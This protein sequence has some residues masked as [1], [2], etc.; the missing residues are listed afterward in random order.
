VVVHVTHAVPLETELVDQIN[1]DI[2]KLFLGQGDLGIRAP[3]RV[4]LPRTLARRQGV[5]VVHAVDRGG[6]TRRS[7]T[8]I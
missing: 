2:L 6:G 3:G 4:G 1:E 7:V 8:A 5:S